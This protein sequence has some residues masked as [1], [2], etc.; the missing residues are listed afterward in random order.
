MTNAS[1]QQLETGSWLAVVRA[2]AECNRRYARMLAHFDLT[3]PQYDVLSAILKL[4]PQATPRRIADELLV[5]RGNVTGLIQRLGQRG[6]ITTRDHDSDGRSFVCEFTPAG[7]DTLKQA[8][9]AAARF[10]RQ[11]LA[12]FD[13]AELEATRDMMTRMRT[14]LHNLDPD[15]LALDAERADMNHDKETTHG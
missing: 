12:V 6:I 4:G 3:I 7:S 2:Y 15:S 11:Q 9:A 10:I 14:H 8:R 5:T 1:R 13:D